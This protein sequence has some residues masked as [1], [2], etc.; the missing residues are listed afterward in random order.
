M[1]LKD[2]F[3]LLRSRV[4]CFFGICKFNIFPVSFSVQ[5]FRD[6][7]VLILICCGLCYTL[8]KSAILS[9]LHWSILIPSWDF[10]AGFPESGPFWYIHYAPFHWHEP[11]T[12]FFLPL[13]SG[14]TTRLNERHHIPILQLRTLKMEAAVSPKR[15]NT[16][17][18]HSVQ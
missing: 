8:W 11:I 1:Q 16:L 15:R 17:H 6:D 3:A 13:E 14:R 10:K 4:F 9:T 2:E 7:T 12:I 5:A 18:F